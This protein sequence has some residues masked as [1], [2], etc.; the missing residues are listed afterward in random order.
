MES[1]ERIHR[2]PAAALGVCLLL[3]CSPSAA[4]QGDAGPAARR[5]LDDL[6]PET[7][8][9]EAARQ[10]AQLGEA[11]LTEILLLLEREGPD[12]LDAGPVATLEKSLQLVQRSVAREFLGRVLA[13]E[14]SP[15][16]DV[17]ALWMYRALAD[18][19]SL[20]PMTQ[21]AN[22]APDSLAPLYRDAVARTLTRDPRA[23]ASTARLGRTAEKPLLASIARAIGDVGAREGLEPLTSLLHHDDDTDAIVLQE[24]AVIARRFPAPFEEQLT[25]RV[26]PFLQRSKGLTLQATV[27]ALGALEDLDSANDLAGL[28]DSPDPKLSSAAL[29]ALRRIGRQPF[30]ARRVLWEVWLQ[31]Q[32]YW[33][34]G[35]APELLAN[36]SEGSPAEV[37]QRLQSLG[38]HGLHRHAIASEVVALLDHEDPIV[39]KFTCAV[40]GQLGSAVAITDLQDARHDEAMAAAAIHALELLAPSEPRAE[41]N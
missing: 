11:G 16:R 3:F 12:S 8:D 14:S 36:L 26:R 5:L 1:P 28:L 25:S 29:L 33:W 24:L 2:W 9:S 30:P 19:A 4:A 34:Q 18:S 21:L 37:V 39:R 23:Y 10:I 38:S 20:L 13:A 31:D 15:P 27:L 35:Q 17:A 22:R 6:A 32:E 40:L 41:R 7:V